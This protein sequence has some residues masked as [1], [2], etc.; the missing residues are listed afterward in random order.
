MAKII[1]DN[2]DYAIIK[3]I[4]MD[5]RM[6]FNE[7]A[8]KLKV[9]E[10][11]VFNRLEK[12]KKAGIVKGFQAIINYELLGYEITAI[13]GLRVSSGMI[14]QVEAEVS[15]KPD[16]LA[17]YDITGEYDALLI[18]RFKSRMQMNDFIKNLLTVKY[19][20]RTNTYLV[21]NTVKE[22]FSINL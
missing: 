7:I 19:V 2:K 5:A 9:S 21:L 4:Q 11:T 16:V 18:C 12:L 17:V 20:E 10:G 15:K 22:N 1:L 3:L 8:R 14:S 13:M 6:P